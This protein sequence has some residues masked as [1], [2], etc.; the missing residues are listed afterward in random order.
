MRP[1]ELRRYVAALMVVLGVQVLSAQE[2]LA[3]VFPPSQRVMEVDVSVSRFGEVRYVSPHNGTY[4]GVALAGARYIVDPDR[5]GGG[6]N[7]FD[8]RT[9]T[10]VFVP[11]AIGTGAS[12]LADPIRPRVFVSTGDGGFAT[13]VSGEVLVLDAETMIARKVWSGPHITLRDYAADPDALYGT[14]RVPGNLEQIVRLDVATGTLQVL[15]TFGRVSGLVADRTGS[16]VFVD[17]VRGSQSATVS[18]LDGRT[19]VLV[20]E[21]ASYRISRMVLDEPRRLLLFDGSPPQALSAETLELVAQLPVINWTGGLRAQRVLP[22]R[23]MTGAYVVRDSLAGP[24]YGCGSFEIGA[25]SPWGGVQAYANLRQHLFPWLVDECFPHI[26]LLRSPFAPE[27]L[28]VAV[29][30]RRVR[31]SW[32]NPGDV[33][34]FEIQAGLA[35]GETA[36]TQ[37]VRGRD[38]SVAFGNVPPGT[39]HVRVR[40]YNEIGGSP[41]SNEIAVTVR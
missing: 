11:F 26:H 41:L 4:G 35:P 39:Y 2:R 36:L 6:F 27:A 40:A 15:A 21:S 31:L 7:V 33:S 23:W 25:L 22:G 13:P 14:V 5:G 30:G 19:G 16:R 38:D 18:A 10:S 37:R 12:L 8:R 17:G 3:L 28:S 1:R 24:F 34:D 29:S 20:A 9:R 32:R